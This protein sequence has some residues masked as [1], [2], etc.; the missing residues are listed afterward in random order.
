MHPFNNGLCVKQTGGHFAERC[1]VFLFTLSI[2][3]SGW[4]HCF[5]W[6][7]CVFNEVKQ[8]RASA[9]YCSVGLVCLLM[10]GIP[11][12]L[13]CSACLSVWREI[14]A[15]CVECLAV[16]C[17]L[18]SPPLCFSTVYQCEGCLSY[19]GRGGSWLGCQVLP[20]ISAVSIWELA[21]NSGSSRKFWG[22]Q[23]PQTQ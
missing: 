3:A 9:V 14:G 23:P 20:A 12:T 2:M 4:N 10:R 19:Q 15:L 13:G 6:F 17:S 22:T 21:A 1:H 11:L 16:F 5:V 18:P 7:C 8:L